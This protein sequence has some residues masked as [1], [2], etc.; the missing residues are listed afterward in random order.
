[1][2]RTISMRTGLVRQVEGNGVYLTAKAQKTLKVATG[3]YVE[4]SNVERGTQ[5]CRRI[6]GLDTKGIVLDDFIY[7][8]IDSLHFLASDLHEEVRVKVSPVAF[9]MP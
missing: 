5:I 8:D 4:I 6:R 3:D 2:N 9:D 7:M 1:M